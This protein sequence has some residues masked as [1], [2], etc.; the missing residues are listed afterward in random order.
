MASYSLVLDRRVASY[1]LVLDIR[2][3]EPLV[4]SG[5]EPV[6]GRGWY[7]NNFIDRESNMTLFDPGQ[8]REARHLSFLTGNVRRA[9][10]SWTGEGGKAL[11]IFLDIERD[12]ALTGPGL[13]MVARHFSF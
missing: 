5:Q 4:I 9:H 2:G 7:G 8:A 6:G 12:V 13:A 1:S 11:I 3:W 10:W